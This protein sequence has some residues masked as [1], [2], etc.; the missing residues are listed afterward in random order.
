[1]VGGQPVTFMVDTGAEH[2]VVATLSRRKV[3]IVGATGTQTNRPFCQP[4]TCQ[5]GGHLVTH[6]FLY[7]PECPI[8]LLGRDL[9]TKL[10]AQ[11]TFTPGGPASLALKD[12]GTFLMAVTVPREDEWRFYCSEKSYTNPESL[13]EEFPK[14]WAEKGPPGW[15]R[16]MHLS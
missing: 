7:V 11:R 9:L 5:L 15:L 8:P 16:T 12:R 2:S 1:M 14:V 10:G 4:R 13:L 6:E 3:T